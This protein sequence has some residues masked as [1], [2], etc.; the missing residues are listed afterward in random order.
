MDAKND[1]FRKYDINISPKLKWTLTIIILIIIV[2][3]IL[4]CFLSKHFAKIY[5]N[6]NG[7]NYKVHKNLED[8]ETA[9]ALLYRLN[10]LSIELL[11]N[12]KEKYVLNATPEK[13]SDPIFAS[14]NHHTK[15]L[16]DHYNPDVLEET[17]PHNI[18]GNTSYVQFKGK[19]FSVCLRY[20]DADKDFHKFNDLTFVM[21]HELAHLARK[22]FGHEPPFWIAFKFLLNEATEIGIYKPI[23]YADKPVN[24]CGLKLEYNPYFDYTT[25]SYEIK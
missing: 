16:L 23:N 17:H 25:P 9:A 1:K 6:V 14:H 21:L 22:D 18:E 8:P 20:K 3:I 15:N 2:S 12:L 11:R 24:Y 4:W 7:E 13:L 5:I 19:I 10:D